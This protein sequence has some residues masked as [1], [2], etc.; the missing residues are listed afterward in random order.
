MKL[1]KLNPWNWFKHED[2][3]GSAAAPVPVKKGE[4]LP[5][6]GGHPLDSFVQLHRDMDRLFD[7][8]FR[9]FGLSGPGRFSHEAFMPALDINQGFK[10]STDVSGDEKQY[11]ISVDLPGMKEG[12]VSIELKDRILTI[13]GETET[14]T[15]S[16]DKKYYRV[17][18]YYGSFQRTLALPEDAAADDI[19]ATMKDGLLKIT[20]PRV[21]MNESD[22][23][24]I[25]IAS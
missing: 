21:A 23:K 3:A 20:V 10:P 17:E 15:D 12:D 24:R 16:D 9:S 11:E 19:H 4:T 18:R 14:K 8:A 6:A 25:S 13:K 22:V 1:E 5:V 2:E 7:E